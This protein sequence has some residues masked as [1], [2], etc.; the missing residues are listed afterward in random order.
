VYVIETTEAQIF[1]C[2]RFTS[3]AANVAKGCTNL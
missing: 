1:N 3:V 2:F